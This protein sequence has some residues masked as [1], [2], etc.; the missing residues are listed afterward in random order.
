MTDRRR[1]STRDLVALFNREQ[2]VCHLCRQA[3]QIGQLWDVSHEIPLALCGSD[4]DSNWRVAHR[5]CHREHTARV[6]QPTIA[7][8]KRQAAAHIGAVRPA[9][10]IQNRG[11]AKS[12][13]AAKREPKT[14]LP[15]RLLYRDI[16]P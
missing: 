5:A 3:I 11:F 16:Q 9:Q 7:K 15:R 2:G 4:D 10:K 1:L 13:R 6:D 12:E 14:A 8:V